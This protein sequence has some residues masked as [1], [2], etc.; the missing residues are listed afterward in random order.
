MGA[1][2]LLYNCGMSIQGISL[3]FKALLRN[4]EVLLATLIVV[5]SLISFALGRFSVSSV[6]ASTSQNATVSEAKESMPPLDE[7][8]AFTAQKSTK[9]DVKENVPMGV[10]PEGGYVASKN[11]TK[12]HLPWC[13]GAKQIKEENKVF[14]KTKEEAE[15]AGYT[16]ASNCKGI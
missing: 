6:G 2:R 4:E 3:K 13:G 5:V 7:E 10:V 8:K 14:F 11:G 15:A 16:P 12:Y 9:S 1:P